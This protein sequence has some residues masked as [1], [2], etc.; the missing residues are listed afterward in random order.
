MRL[1]YFRINGATITN[2]LT[3]VQIAGLTGVTALSGGYMHTVALKSDATLVAWGFDYDGQLGDGHYDVN[4][5]PK[6]VLGLDLAPPSGTII[7]NDSTAYTNST[8]VTLSLPAT[9]DSGIVS[10]MRIS[11][12][13][14]FD[15]DPG[16]AM[17]QPQAGT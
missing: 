15:T 13:G 3:P 17:L 7:I 2:S 8:T 16:R 9:D 12:D 6:M 1:Q 11:N 4:P 10:Q 14:V 5:V